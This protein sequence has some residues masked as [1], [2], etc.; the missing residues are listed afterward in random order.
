MWRALSVTIPGGFVIGLT[1][2]YVGNQ[3]G[4]N[5]TNAQIF[6]NILSMLLGLVIGVVFLTKVMKKKY[7]GFRVALVEEGT[8]NIEP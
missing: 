6:A 5:M 7:K 4:V 8:K 1:I 2:S 3:L